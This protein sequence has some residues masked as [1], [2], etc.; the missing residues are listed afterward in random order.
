MEAEHMSGA[1]PVNAN[2]G[3]CL[4]NTAVLPSIGAY[5]T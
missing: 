5:P 1:G 2:Y 4:K 3:G